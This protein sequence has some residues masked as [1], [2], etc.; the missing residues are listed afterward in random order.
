MGSPAISEVA[1]SFAVLHGRLAE[2]VVGAR[3]AALGHARR[4]DLLDDRLDRRRPRLDASRARHVADGAETDR[5]DERILALDALDV[6]RDRVQHPVAAEDLALVREVD[7]R[8]LELLAGNVL[9]DVELGPVRN[10]EDADVLAL[11]DARVVEAPQ[12]GSL[13]ARVPLAEVVAKGE[14]PLLRPAPL[15]VAAGAADRRVEAVLLDRVEQRRRLQPVARRTRSC[16][17][18]DAALVDRLL[19]GRDDEPLAELRDAAVAVLD[20]LREV[21]PRIDVHDRERK[22]ARPERLLGE[23]QQDDRVLAAGEEQHR[24]LELRGDL[25]ED[26][27][28]LGLELVEVREGRERTRPGAHS[29]STFSGR[30]LSSSSRSSTAAADSLGIRPE[31]S[32]RSSGWSGSSYGAETP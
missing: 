5:G 11:A 31:V 15:L 14:N 24:P 25:T 3:L 20:R 17:L 32:R 27:D 18:D 1:N 7:A 22:L 13:R 19:H 10:R 12:L 29:A 16:L 6:R 21:V 2:T 28:S 9:P 30:R 8:Q 4:R 26:V 23:P